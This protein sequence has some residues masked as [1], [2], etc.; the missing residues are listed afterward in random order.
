MLFGALVVGDYGI[1]MDEPIERKPLRH[2]LGRIV[3]TIIS[4]YL[5]IRIYDTQC[6]AKILKR[7]YAAHVFKDPFL[8]RWLFNVEILKRLQLDM[9]NLDEVVKDKPA[10]FIDLDRIKKSTLH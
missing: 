2:Y 5:K 10:R 7:E 4:L 3:A 6:G 9:D 1:S 8:S